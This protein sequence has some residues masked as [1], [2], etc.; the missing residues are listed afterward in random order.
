[1]YDA[2]VKPFKLPNFSAMIIFYLELIRK[3]FNVD[4]VHFITRRKKTKFK[5][6]RE[7]VPFIVHCRLALQVLETMLQD[8][9]LEQG[10]TTWKYDPLGFINNKRMELDI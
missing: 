7:V 6:K 3:I 1:M 4:E 2:E 9:G 8:L 5:P 10:G